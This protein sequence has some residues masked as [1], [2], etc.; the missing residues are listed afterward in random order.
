MTSSTQL[1]S[2]Y[3]QHLVM[4]DPNMLQ[5]HLV[6]DIHNQK[7]SMRLLTKNT[8]LR[9]VAGSRTL[10]YRQLDIY[11]DSPFHVR[12]INHGAELFALHDIL[13]AENVG[14]TRGD[15]L[16]LATIPDCYTID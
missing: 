3:R 2:M 16:R 8:T 6:L 12:Q 7:P 1:T 11:C 10:S 5:L 9:L 13:A 4:V 14:E 15:D